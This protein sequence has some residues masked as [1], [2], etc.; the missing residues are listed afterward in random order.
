MLLSSGQLKDLDTAIHIQGL[1]AD[2]RA[3]GV[4]GVPLARSTQG[5]L[6][7]PLNQWPQRGP[8]GP[9]PRAT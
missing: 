2:F 5:R 3:L 6:P 7:P 9:G 4:H 8:N 1:M